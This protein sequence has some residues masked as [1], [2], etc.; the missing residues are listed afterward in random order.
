MGINFDVF[1]FSFRIFANRR[2]NGGIVTRIAI[3]YAMWKRKTGFG[4][5]PRLIASLWSRDLKN[6]LRFSWV[7]I[8]RRT[9]SVVLSDSKE[10]QKLVGC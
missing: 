3:W 6:W 10:E 8:R 7:V 5:A 4:V 1:G 9:C 2:R